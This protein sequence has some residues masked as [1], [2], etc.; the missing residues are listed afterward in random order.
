MELTLNTKVYTNNPISGS[1]NKV[2]Q[3]T[4]TYV[5][6]EN[7]WCCVDFGP[8]RECRFM[9]DVWASLKDAERE[10]K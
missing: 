7:N 2:V 8:F 6:P 1:S 9:Q 5:H 4:V 10:V 3:G